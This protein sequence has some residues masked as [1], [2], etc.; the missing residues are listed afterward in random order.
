[1]G[2]AL[3]SQYGFGD[4]IPKKVEV[5]SAMLLFFYRKRAKFNAEVAKSLSVFANYFASLRLIY[6]Y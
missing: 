1:V 3:A 2:G 4:F 6:F 5:M